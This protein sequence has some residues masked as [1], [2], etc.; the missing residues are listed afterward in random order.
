[1][2]FNVRICFTD[3][4]PV[5]VD[6]SRCLF[7]SLRV[8]KQPY[9]PLSAI[10]SAL[11]I[12][13]VLNSVFCAPHHSRR[14][15][16]AHRLRG[17]R[18]TYSSCTEG[19]PGQREGGHQT[20]TQRREAHALVEVHLLLLSVKSHTSWWSKK[21][22]VNPTSIASKPLSHIRKIR[23]FASPS[24]PTIMIPIQTRKGFH[25]LGSN[26]YHVSAKVWSACLLYYCRAP[27]SRL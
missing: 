25:F 14:P 24:M 27:K 19:R 8:F 26:N 2:G 7:L 13:I 16:R 20:T 10:V 15:G 22:A 4:L 9:A 6:S 18:L 17:I 21:S 1:M 11:P 5:E 23:K 12:I 3:R